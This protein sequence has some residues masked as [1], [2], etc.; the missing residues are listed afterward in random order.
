MST[1]TSDCMTMHSLGDL[2]N[3]PI[4]RAEDGYARPVMPLQVPAVVG[5]ARAVLVQCR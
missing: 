3:V 1:E 2:S 4:C 5:C